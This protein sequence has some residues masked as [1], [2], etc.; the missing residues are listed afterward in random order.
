MYTDEELK[1]DEPLKNEILFTPIKTRLEDVESDSSF[2]R[3][4]KD[5]ESLLFKNLEEI[6]KI[7]DYG[8]FYASLGTTDADG[9]IGELRTFLRENIK[10]WEK[11]SD[12]KIIYDKILFLDRAILD[13]VNGVF[14]IQIN[15]GVIMSS[16]PFW[17]FFENFFSFSYKLSN[18]KRTLLLIYVS[19]L[20]LNTCKDLFF[21]SR[22]KHE[23]FYSY[24]YEGANA[25]N[26]SWYQYV[27]LIVK[28]ILQIKYKSN[29]EIINIVFSSLLKLRD[30]RKLTPLDPL[31]ATV[32]QREG[33]VL[34]NYA[35]QEQPSINPD[36]SFTVSTLPQSSLPNYDP[37]T[38]FFSFG[39]NLHGALLNRSGQKIWLVFSGTKFSKSF[40]QIPRMLSNVL[41]DMF[42]I[43]FTVDVSYLV[44]VGVIEKVLEENP[45]KAIDVYGHSLGGGLMQFSV[46]ALSAKYGDRLRGY[47]YNSAGLS[48]L[49]LSL[50]NVN[51]LNKASGNIE[52]IVLKKDIVSRVGSLIGI[53]YCL[54]ERKAKKLLTAHFIETV[55]RLLYN[56]QFVICQIV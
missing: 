35:Y 17:D 39:S 44:A 20:F 19:T 8:P 32:D 45:D 18:V 24:A 11:G 4:L 54:K 33:A 23:N 49:T 2:E 50:L 27:Y 51:D 40:E 25:I 6:L 37:Q 42:Q 30:N 22:H 21:F 38:G 55:I 10:E 15:C 14:H 46:Q 34:S 9:S 7:E 36:Y 41:T 12:S 52:H 29:L 53:N 48:K 47:G 43:M 5:L 1:I 26:L 56:G 13:K 3:M 31:F 16:L 28:T